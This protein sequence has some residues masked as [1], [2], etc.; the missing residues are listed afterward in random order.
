MRLIFFGTSHGVP[1][2]NR[3]CSCA[4]VECGTRRYFVDM[5]VQAIDEMITRDMAPDSVKGIFLTHLH[6]DHI[7]GLVSFVDLSNWF[8]RTI[9][10]SI[11]F[12]DARGIQAL[13]GWFSA[14]DI[15]LRPMDFRVIQPGVIYED[16]VLRVTACRTKHCDV[17]YSFLLEE[18]ETGKKM[19]FTGDL[20]SPDV[21][22]PM[23]LLAERPQIV[24]CETAHFDAAL[25]EPIF[26]NCGAE[27]IIFNH[28]GVQYGRSGVPLIQAL[29][30]KLD[31][32]VVIASDGTE[33]VL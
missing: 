4:L 20:R 14:L 28:Y 16:G 8:F 11:L 10:A 1:E 32:P 7:N 5:G 2:K 24:V 6:G 27:K 29:A 15:S 22:F 33:A 17:S 3:H 25:Y 30:K 26:K 21:D 31:I 23:S 12:P 18:V 19:L 13:N 9:E